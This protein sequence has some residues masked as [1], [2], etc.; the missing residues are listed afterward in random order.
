MPESL[1]KQRVFHEIRGCAPRGSGRRFGIAL[2]GDDE[3]EET[4][5]EAGGG[6]DVGRRG[7]LLWMG[8]GS[9]FVR[10]RLKKW[11]RTEVALAAALPTAPVAD[12]TAP[13]PE[14]SAPEALDATEPVTEA[15]PDEAPD[16]TDAAPLC[17]DAALF[18]GPVVSRRSLRNQSKLTRGKRRTRR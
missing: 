17:P 7:S 16:A 9:T 5:E 4:G 10:A 3:R 14:E 1:R 11:V 13:V 15:R 12:P 18:V 2:N 6:N 8:R